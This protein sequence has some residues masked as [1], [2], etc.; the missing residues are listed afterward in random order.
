MG[1]QRIWR[2]FARGVDG[3]SNTSVVVFLFLTNLTKARELEKRGNI[4]A[5]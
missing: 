5:Y 3:D 2:S 4:S 1:A